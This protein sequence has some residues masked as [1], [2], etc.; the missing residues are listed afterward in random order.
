MK[1]STIVQQILTK[2]HY[3]TKI[4]RGYLEH[5]KVS[6][7]EISLKESLE[8][9]AGTAF[10]VSDA[11]LKHALI[12]V[13]EMIGLTASCM[14]TNPL[15]LMGIKPFLTDW[16][17]VSPPETTVCLIPIHQLSLPGKAGDIPEQW[18]IDYIF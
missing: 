5:L 3:S 17:L 6:F 2:Q 11:L 1:N 4:F 16:N 8:G 13:G 18:E 10:P 7:P 15:G 12:S 9:I 14:A